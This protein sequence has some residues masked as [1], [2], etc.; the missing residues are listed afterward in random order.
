[1]PVGDDVTDPDLSPLHRFD[2][3]LITLDEKR[4]HGLAVEIQRTPLVRDGNLEFLRNQPSPGFHAD[5][6]PLRM[7]FSSSPNGVICGGS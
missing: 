1:M 7:S 6:S 4:A 3:D 5:Y 2:D